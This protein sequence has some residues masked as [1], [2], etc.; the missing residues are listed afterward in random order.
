MY[1][2]KTYFVL[3]RLEQP[4]QDKNLLYGHDKPN[5]TI[6]EEP[7]SHVLFESPFAPVSTVSRGHPSLVPRVMPSHLF[8]LTVLGLRQLR[9]C[10]LKVFVTICLRTSLISRFFE[11]C[12]DSNP[13]SCS[14][15]SE[16]YRN[17]LAMP[18]LVFPT[19]SH[20]YLSH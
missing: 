18:P 12:L 3:G 14:Y 13:K 8:L 11:E 20:I 15:L 1:G 5:E 4:R 2:E 19:Y 17:N 6:K 7:L 9:T 16:K 10:I